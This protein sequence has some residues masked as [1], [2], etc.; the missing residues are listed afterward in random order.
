LK[1][2]SLLQD[3]RTAGLPS[4]VAANTNDTY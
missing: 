2:K 4:F 3:L 1:T